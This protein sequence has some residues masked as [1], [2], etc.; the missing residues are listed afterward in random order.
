M[1]SLSPR[2]DLF[3]FVLPKDFLPKPVEA[4]YY[5]LFQQNAGVLSTPIDYL[6]ESIMGIS[7]PGIS[8]INIAQEQHGSNSISTSNIRNNGGLGK[9]NVEPKHEIVYTSS[10]NPLEKIE[11]EFKVTFRQNQGLYNYFMIYETIFY[12]ICKPHLYPPIGRLYIDIL[13]EEGVAVSRLTLCD[14]HLDGIEGLEFEY[15]KLERESGSFQVTFKFNN[16]DFEL[17]DN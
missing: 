16:I 13:N 17:M 2:M 3:R 8:D 9:I 10:D 7:F 6:N 4:K 14:C 1:L 11:K 15:T 5:K 12:K